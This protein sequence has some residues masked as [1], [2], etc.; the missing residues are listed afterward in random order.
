MAAACCQRTKVSSN[1]TDCKKLF[2]PYVTSFFPI[3]FFTNILS[4]RDSLLPAKY[5]Y[6]N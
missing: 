4:L 5:W 3:F 1:K 2:H 6:L